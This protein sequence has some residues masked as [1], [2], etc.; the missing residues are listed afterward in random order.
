MSVCAGECV[1]TEFDWG[2]RKKGIEK[3][4]DHEKSCLLTR[5]SYL[6]ISVIFT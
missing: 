5:V 3:G 4:L 2:E 1:N 6:S